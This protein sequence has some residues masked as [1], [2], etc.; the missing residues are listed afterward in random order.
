M[1]GRALK[2]LFFYDNNQ[3][4]DQTIVINP[5]YLIIHDTI[6]LNYPTYPPSVFLA[7]KKKKKSGLLR[8]VL[9]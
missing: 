5:N 6:V 2:S 4:I 8:H 1:F 7:T 9:F 3:V